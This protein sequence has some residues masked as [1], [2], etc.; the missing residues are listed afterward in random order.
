MADSSVKKQIVEK[1]KDSNNILVTVNTS[2][3]LDELSAA[4][5]I[6]L[7]L[8]KLDK[9]A[10]AVFSG[11]V[12]SA[13]EF[14]K[15]EKTFESTVDSLRD[16]IIA[17]DKEKA[18]HLR[19]KVEGDM[20]K[21]FITPYR[22]TINQDDLDFSQ[23]D[24]NVDTVL[25]IGVK[26]EED[27][28]R[29]LES[30]GRILH[31][32]T[33]ATVSI[34][35]E[36]NIDGLQW[37]D[38]NAS[39]YCEMIFSLVEDLK[40]GK[41][42]VDEQIANAF[43]TGIVAATNRFSNDNTNSKVMTVAAQLMSA[44]ANQQLI[45]S[46]LEES[47]AFT[48]IEEPTE[49]PEQEQSNDNDGKLRE[50]ERQKV[51]RNGEQPKKTVSEKQ[52]SD[53]SLTI[54]HMPVGTIDEV[55]DQIAERQGSEAARRAEEELAR[56]TQSSGD[57]KS[58]MNAI[59]PSGA[60]PSLAAPGGN[61]PEF[62]ETPLHAT[63]LS[64]QSQPI[65]GG[66]LNATTEQ[67]AE[68]ARRALDQDRNHTLLSHDGSGYLSGQPAFQSSLNAASDGKDENAGVRDI[69]A[70]SHKSEPG[71]TAH[72][73]TIQPAPGLTL[74]EID[75]QNRATAPAVSS[76]ASFTPAPLPPS[77]QDA[78]GAVHAAFNG[79]QPFS[80]QTVSPFSAS[81]PTTLP[82]LPPMPD[83]STLPPLPG[84]MS[85]PLPETPTMPPT[86]A[87]GTQTAPSSAI[88]STLEELLPPVPANAMPMPVPASQP[89][90]PSQ[91]KIPGQ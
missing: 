25:A 63:A 44:G 31:D 61:M 16:F 52:G 57:L 68:D 54:N 81:A 83:F 3:T 2:P 76:S 43:L 55:G 10:T 35:A 18:D 20:V 71:G 17:L 33:V 74:A 70:D 47:D 41:N 26:S 32:A 6:T 13:I 12:P 75:K 14:L 67:A 36:T 4:L 7:L 48:P 58:V 1:V 34:D 64:P 23:G 40:S 49:E 42:L 22:T 77:R 24:Y 91:F 11:E 19:Y 90:D 9:H 60:L 53:G 89:S 85:A 37:I 66:T 73:A 51:N 21:I 87:F 80:P 65:M 30:H 5:G 28:D 79:P 39:S 15:P 62:E 88:P 84:A 45:A 46:R 72:A 59:P 38:S 78:L 56:Q 86:A 69:F 29:A 27:L 82:P 50:G 8:N